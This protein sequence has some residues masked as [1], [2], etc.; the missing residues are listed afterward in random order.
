MQT[1]FGVDKAGLNANVNGIIDNLLNAQEAK[2]S[3]KLML[4][5]EAPVATMA[6]ERNGCQQTTKV[7]H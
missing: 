2:E 1:Q 3:T 6:D 7:I 5:G 4:Q